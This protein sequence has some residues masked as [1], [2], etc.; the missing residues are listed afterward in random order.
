M[1]FVYVPAICFVLFGCGSSGAAVE[2]PVVEQ[3]YVIRI[4]DANKRIFVLIADAKM[5]KI[6]EMR[7]LIHT[8]DSYVRHCQTRWTSNWSASF[9]Q[10]RETAGYK[11]DPNI[12]PYLS[13]GSWAKSYI[14][15]YSARTGILVHYP[16]QPDK[17]YETTVEHKE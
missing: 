9:F 3:E 16:M 11:H 17:R 15:E 1:K 13:D 7:E 10:S 8:L 5:Q 4:D 12:A 6:L 14:G 2:C